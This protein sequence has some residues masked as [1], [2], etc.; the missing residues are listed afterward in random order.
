[1]T[2]WD[3]ISTP[4]QEQTPQSKMDTSA[5]DSISRPDNAAIDVTDRAKAQAD[6][7]WTLSKDNG[8][9]LQEAQQL[10]AGDEPGAFGR[11][12]NKIR[13]K[14]A[15]TTGLFQYNTGYIKPDNRTIV[16]K[17]NL[18]PAVEFTQQ[19]A[20]ETARMTSAL[21]LGAL[22]VLAHET[23]GDL[24]FADMIARQ[25]GYVPDEAA[26]QVGG[27]AELATM[28]I[29]SGAAVGKLF[30]LYRAS[31][32]GKYLRTK[33]RPTKVL[34]SMVNCGLV[35]T[36]TDAAMQ[37]SRKLTTGE[38]I[39]WSHVAHEGEI[40]TIIGTGE[41]AVA[42]G[43]S[44]LGKGMNK[45]LK[46]AK[47]WLEKRARDKKVTAD[48]NAARAHYRKYGKMPDDLMDFYVGTNR[49]GKAEAPKAGTPAKRGLQLPEKTE[50]TVKLET[51]ESKDYKKRVAESR[52]LVKQHP[53]Y[54]EML[55]AYDAM[56]ALLNLPTKIDFGNL[57]T[58][59]LE[60]VKGNKYL[61]AVIGKP[62]EG[63]PFDLLYEDMTGA[64]AESAG[65]VQFLR[66]PRSFFETFG[67]Y[68]EGG[69]GTDRLNRWAIRQASKS[70]EFQM[71]LARYD[72]VREGMNPAEIEQQLALFEKEIYGKPEEVKPGDSIPAS[73]EGEVQKTGESLSTYEPETGIQI[74][75]E[76]A[77]KI[78][79]GFIDDLRND[80][81]VEAYA[82]A[83][84]QEPFEMEVKNEVPEKVQAEGQVE[85]D[86]SKE[87]TQQEIDDLAA[88]GKKKT[89]IAKMDVKEGRS[90]L[91]ENAEKLQTQKVDAAI[92]NLEK[93][94]PGQRNAGFVDLT[95]MTN[96][97]QEL[98]A[99]GVD[100]VKE[101]TGGLI[102]RINELRFYPN[103]PP[104]FQNAVR[105]ELIGAGNRISNKIHGEIAP[106]IFGNLSK[107]EIQQAAEIMA[108]R[109][110]LERAT[111][112]MGNP[113]LTEQELLDALNA[114]ES[115]ASPAV[116][117]LADDAKKVQDIIT[118]RL[119]DRGL[120]NPDD[121]LEYYVRHYTLDYTPDWA[122]K[123]GSLPM[124]LRSPYRGYTKHATGSIK[125]YKRDF[126]A[127]LFS[128][129]E[130]ELDNVVADFIDKWASRYDVTSM[131]SDA[132]KRTMFGLTPNLK[133]KKPKPG[134]I[135]EYNGK[136]YRGW[137]PESPFNRTFYRNE[138]GEMVMGGYKKT[139]VL[140]I[141]MY[142]TFNKMTIPTSWGIY[143]INRATRLWKSFAI[144]SHYTSFNLNNL[145]G[146]TTLA[147]TQH[148]QPAKLINE[149]KTAITY[150]MN[151]GTDPYYK[152]LNDFIVR[153]DILKG[154]GSVSE[155]ATFRGVENP[156]AALLHK[157]NQF[158]EFRESINRCAYASS[159]FRAMKEGRG[160]E[161]VK[162]HPWINT[163]GLSMDEALGKIAREVEHDYQRRSRAFNRYISGFMLP[164][165]SWPLGMSS[166]MWKWYGRNIIKGTAL[167][168]AG[169]VIS[170]AFNERNDEISNLE[171]QLPES[172]KNKIHFV[173]GKN[174]D[175]TTRVL[176]I[177]AP[178]DALIGL[179]GF[180]IATA[181]AKRVMT[182]ELTAKEAAVRALKDW[183]LKETKGMFF[184]LS[185]TI[186][187]IS[188]LASSRRVDPYDNAPI[189]DKNPQDLTA[190]QWGMQT[191]AFATKCAVPLLS[192]TISN[193]EKGLPQDSAMDK[194]LDTL[195]G[196]GALGIYDITPKQEI[197][198]ELEDGKTI[199]I[200]W[201]DNA[202]IEWVNQQ[203]S[204]VLDKFEDDY[205]D[206]GK[207]PL[208][209]YSTPK[210]QK[211]LLEVFS[212]WKEFL[213]DDAIPETD[214]EKIA[215]V[216]EKLGDQLVNR[217]EST[218][219][220]DKWYK[221][222][223]SRA[224]TEQEKTELG[225]TYQLLGQYK[226]QDAIQ[227]QPKAAR[228]LWL[229][230]K[231]KGS[232]DLPIELLWRMP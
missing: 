64:L 99:P 48:V 4:V 125:P 113:A 58:D 47:D 185:P 98:L 29:P 74:T 222:A 169:P 34:E 200:G 181:Y 15:E 142:E 157:M 28:F 44:G 80:A 101:T 21:S 166:T 90:L 171:R 57:R 138:E 209:F 83:I 160:A 208:E 165:G 226:L 168:M 186:R 224:K 210:A 68:Y 56:T 176:C 49:T 65:D 215:F 212:V 114:M 93:P 102:D 143:Q 131:L 124:R 87:F 10:I 73:V 178:Q 91:K 5:W 129:Y 82:D 51:L 100:Y 162:A 115:A 105:V 30:K 92:S 207:T 177:Q 175:G 79:S 154:A 196:K 76:Q 43:L 147:L 151:N 189:Y 97:V 111:K 2:S 55:S 19:T 122:F 193:Y 89:D 13:E 119:V 35:F 85:P 72:M 128:W 170:A 218:R 219:V 187:F 88:L 126:E 220:L 137:C 192:F 134:K 60:A 183:G 148:P 180:T 107:D 41:F 201:E 103:M 61:E 164:F 16:N 75:D 40:G 120:I 214:E 86:L 203:T 197:K 199:L 7:A 25:S 37:F 52:E 9:P 133:I 153:N 26:Q 67:S 14:I 106:A 174:A 53:V 127:I 1:M 213:P 11:V 173:F 22:D 205:V 195:V 12:F 130:M 156:I 206:S 118:K 8:I 132:E 146:D 23:E 216:S 172:I 116:I 227:K 71:E 136:K 18:A 96:T 20:Y 223:M 50:S 191:A 94:K 231:I 188:G 159:L 167:L 121:M 108:G 32:A 184:M 155:L 144:A 194:M 149:Y 202:K 211:S 69:M 141:E 110:A 27:Y 59:A 104:E 117:K 62:G 36:S 66:D 190:F 221:V 229:G 139:Y 109:D 46:S 3:D 39:D 123:R 140:P 150:L 182:G 95:G 70:P 228:E 217:F 31:K 42:M 45:F 33:V 77:D 81:K 63:K 179:K 135:Y 84:N 163:R 78:I 158:S 38:D 198:V 230:K 112:G 161:M 54:Q 204:A 225:K 152:E 232:D 17:Y 24:T 145:I 6:E